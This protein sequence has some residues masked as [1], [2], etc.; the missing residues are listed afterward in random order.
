MCGHGSLDLI[1]DFKFFAAPKVSRRIYLGKR[2]VNKSPANYIPDRLLHSSWRT[3]LIKE[4]NC[5]FAAR[6][7]LDKH[8]L[9][10][11]G[12]Y[13]AA[14]HAESI[15]IYR[16]HLAIDD[17][18]IDGIRRVRSAVLLHKMPDIIAENKR[19]GHHAPKAEMRLVLLVTELAVADL[20][21]IGVVP[22]SDTRVFIEQHIYLIYADN[23]RPHR[24]D[25]GCGAPKIARLCAPAPREIE[26]PFAYGEHYRLAVL[27]GV[28]PCGSFK[29]RTHIRI[30]NCGAVLLRGNG[31][32][33]RDSVHTVAQSYPH[34]MPAVGGETLGGGQGGLVSLFAVDDYLEILIAIILFN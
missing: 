6:K 3:C 32:I 24:L 18:G 1:T 34:L 4:A 14:L 15:L 25:I 20:K 27:L 10:A 7:R 13:P 23:R 22:R 30:L 31:I 26:A 8:I 11:V 5:K 21:H 17:Y 2:G 29:L 28:L 12:L 19:R 33:N 9:G 16:Y